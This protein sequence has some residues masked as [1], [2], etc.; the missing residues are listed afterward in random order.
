MLNPAYKKTTIHIRHKPIK[1]TTSK[2]AKQP[3]RLFISE[4]SRHNYYENYT[5]EEKTL[6]GLSCR[7]DAHPNTCE[8]T[9]TTTVET[10]LPS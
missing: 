6:D 2:N 8:P 1:E 7:A 3:T 4:K 9:N 10:T 5:E